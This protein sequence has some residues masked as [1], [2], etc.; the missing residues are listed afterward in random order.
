MARQV[1]CP[2]GDPITIT[3]LNG[4]TI[5]LTTNDLSLPQCVLLPLSGTF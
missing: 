2:M 5:K 4:H 1:T 3:L